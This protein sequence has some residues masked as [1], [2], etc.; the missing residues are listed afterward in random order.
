[1]K[2]GGN[3]G[4]KGWCGGDVRNTTVMQNYLSEIYPNTFGCHIFTEWIS[5]HIYTRE[6]AQI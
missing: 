4:E 3:A 6:M 5:E 1:M 2:P